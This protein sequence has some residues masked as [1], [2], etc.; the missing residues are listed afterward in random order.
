MIS[1]LEAAEKLRW[2]GLCVLPAKFQS[3]SPSVKW[4]DRTELPTNDELVGW[5]GGVSLSSYWVLCGR[6]SGVAVFDADNQAAID[7]AYKEIGA[8][9]LDATPCV[10]TA[11]GMHWWFRL[12]QDASGEGYAALQGWSRHDDAKDG[13]GVSFDLRADGGGV[14]CPPSIHQTGIVYR[15]VRSPDDVEFQPLPDVLRRANGTA[16]LSGQGKAGT[17]QNGDAAPREAKDSLAALLAKMPPDGGRN[18]WLTKVCGHLAKQHEFSD[19][20]LANVRL[21]NKGLSLPL[22]DDEVTKTAVSIWETE[23]R[24]TALPPAEFIPKDLTETAAARL[25]ADRVRGIAWYVPGRSWMVYREGEG[26]FIED[27][28][29]ALHLVQEAMCDLRAEAVRRDDKKA[30]TFGTNMTSARGIAAILKLAQIDPSLRARVSDFDAHPSL[31]NVRNGVLD[32]ESGELLPHHSAFMFTQRAGTKWD[33]E[34]KCPLWEAHLKRVLEND[35]ALVVFMQRWAGRALSGIS[36]SDNCRIL[37]PYGTGANGKTV[38]VETLSMVMGEYA[39]SC[40]FQT[41]CA[42]AESGGSS[43]RQDL[44]E[45]VGARLVTATESGY[46]HRLDEAL[47]KAYTGGEKVSPRGMFAKKATVY[48]PQFSLLLSTNHLPRLEGSDL[49]FWRRFLKVGF[50]VEIPE[51]DR[52]EQFL[53]KMRAE[54]PGVLRWAH[55]GYQMWKYRTLDPP[56]SVLL[57]TAQF[58]CDIDWVGQFVEQKLVQRHDG[59]AEMK[60]IYEAYRIWCGECGIVRPLTLQQFSNRL[61]EHGFEK[62]VEKGSRKVTLKGVELARDERRGMESWVR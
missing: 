29:A 2:W 41:W 25:L 30:I 14:I 53:E 12:P 18:V 10:Q 22:D 27:D 59:Y 7:W 47:L 19:G 40:D 13:T 57:E 60:A 3:K 32:L 48:T 52:D 6:V 50:K 43:Q 61:M 15:W 11:K 45:L 16:A 21:V 37:M 56:T 49:G 33:P 26:R 24:K 28:D 39:R 34:A 58:R 38:T 23:K 31:L 46:H 36:Q 4:K 42:G 8:A 1:P 35:E 17:G 9:V 44:V 55:E 54:L 62:S 20:Y 51:P 5:F